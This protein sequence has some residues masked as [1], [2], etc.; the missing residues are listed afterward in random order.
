MTKIQPRKD[1]LDTL[2]EIERLLHR[3]DTCIELFVVLAV[4]A[5]IFAGC[6]LIFH[7]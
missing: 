7:L 4:L 1:E 3:I 6:S 2:F 5:A